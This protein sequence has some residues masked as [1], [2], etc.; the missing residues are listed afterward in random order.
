MHVTGKRLA[1]NKTSNEKI[2]E[3]EV[4]LSNT[5]MATRISQMML[6]QMLEQF[7]NLRRDMDN[8][9]GIINDIQYRTIAML[10]VG[11]INKDEL[12]AKAE[13]LKLADYNRASDQEDAIKGYENDDNGIIGEKSIVIITSTTNGDND[14]GIFRSKFNMEE[15]RTESLREKLIGAKVG[16]VIDTELNG[17]LH[18]ITVLGLRK[19]KVGENIGE[20]N[21]SN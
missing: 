1:K 15:C 3:L 12:E 4:A 6:K 18:T 16:D 2:K 9:M 8:T 13:E 14:K 20:E 7:Q 19:I 5:E 17:D 21:Q 10:E 11:N